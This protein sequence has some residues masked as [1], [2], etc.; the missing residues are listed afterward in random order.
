MTDKFGPILRAAREKKGLTQLDVAKHLNYDHTFISKLECGK[1]SLPDLDTLLRWAF[2]VGAK[3]IIEN[4]VISYPAS[5][6]E[7][8]P[9]QAA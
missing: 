2:Y 3:R 9:Q 1:A 4:Y 7:A 5:A 8:P 6:A